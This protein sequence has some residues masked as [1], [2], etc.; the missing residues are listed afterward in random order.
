MEKAPALAGSRPNTATDSLYAPEQG[1]SSQRPRSPHCTMTGWST[2][3]QHP[4]QSR[5][6]DPRNTY[7]PWYDNCY[8]PAGHSLTHCSYTNSTPRDSGEKHKMLGSC[9]LHGSPPV[10]TGPSAPSLNST[11]SSPHSLSLRHSHIFFHLI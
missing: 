11:C 10:A 3:T 9:W 6:P 1:P 2:Q 4:F 7:R 5:F 8:C